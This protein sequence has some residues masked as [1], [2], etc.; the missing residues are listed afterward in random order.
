MLSDSFTFIFVIFDSRVIPLNTTQSTIC[1]TVCFYISIFD[2]F[3]ENPKVFNQIN[4]SEY[5]EVCFNFTLFYYFF[6][7]AFQHDFLRILFLLHFWNSAAL[8][9]YLPIPLRFQPPT[10]FIRS[11][12]LF[13]IIPHLFYFSLV[14]E[15]LLD[16]NKASNFKIK[17]YFSLQFSPFCKMQPFYTI[18]FSWLHFMSVS[19]SK[20]N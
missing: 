20:K 18:Y 2:V 13:Q 6:L 14:S 11:P 3:Q 10:L 9:S 16:S 7:R 8:L 12:Q 1:Q 19:S 15:C 5:C 4:F 17:Y